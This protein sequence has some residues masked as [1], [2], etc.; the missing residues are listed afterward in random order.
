[1]CCLLTA[2]ACNTLWLEFEIVNEEEGAFD[3]EPDVENHLEIPLAVSSDAAD[4]L[5]TLSNYFEARIYSLYFV[6]TANI[7]S[8]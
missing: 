5:N 7:L 3:L 2:V 8:K 4:T 6:L 1:M